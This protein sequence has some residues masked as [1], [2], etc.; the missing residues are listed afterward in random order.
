MK[1]TA[2]A[3]VLIAVFC[4]LTGC[5]KVRNSVTSPVSYKYDNS[6]KYIAGNGSVPASQVKNL[7]IDWVSGSVR[8]IPGSGSE[9]RFYEEY[10]GALEDDFVMRWYL[11]GSNLRI[12]YRKAGTLVGDTSDK[13]LTVEVPSS[14]ILS[15]LDV[16]YVSCDVTV[17]VN[18]VNY[19]FDGVSGSLTLKADT[20]RIVEIDTVSGNLNM[21][22][23]RCPDKL[24]ID[25]VSG[26]ASVRIPSSSGF[27]ASFDSVSGSFKSS[28]PMTIDGKRYIAGDGKSD[29]S[30]DS[31]SGSVEIRF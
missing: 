4:V 5:V 11:D 3:V 2:V 17:Q 15:N 13:R 31:V 30:F 8:V 1:K 6:D 19:G 23:A 20:P 29:F 14:L 26:N 7:D 24:D 16:D 22:F 21:E 28:I 18:A 27:S 9:V 10:K 12:R 25:S